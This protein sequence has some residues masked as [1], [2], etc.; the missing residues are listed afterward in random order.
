MLGLGI[1][2]GVF[3]SIHACASSPTAV[4][5]LVSQTAMA[6]A[7]NNG[8]RIRTVILPGCNLAPSIWEEFDTT[9]RAKL[10]ETIP[11]VQFVGQHDPVG[12]DILVNEGLSLTDGLELQSE[13][14]DSKLGST[15][16]GKTFNKF[17]GCVASHPAC[18]YC[19]QTIYASDVKDKKIESTIV[20]LL[21]TIRT[22]G[23][24][25][26]VTVVKSL[27]NDLDQRAIEIVQGWR[28]RPAM[29]N[30]GT[31]PAVLKPISTRLPVAITI[32]IP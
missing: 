16:R 8:R 26:D 23:R 10:A 32:R 18:L 17:Q 6:A 30:L 29:R 28:F 21:V 11:G 22:D 4:Q 20:S 15:T 9:L 14:V 7:L 19:P 31:D 2:L 13:I 27:D 1:F 25:G 3:L 24:A 12:A 5:D